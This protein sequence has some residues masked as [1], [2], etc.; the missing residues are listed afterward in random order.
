MLL[1]LLWRLLLLLMSGMLLLLL[2]AWLL[3]GRGHGL[4]MEGGRQR[5]VLVAHRVR[6]GGQQQALE[7]ILGNGDGGRRMVRRMRVVGGVVWIRNVGRRQSRRRARTSGVRGR[8]VRALR[9]IRPARWRERVV[10]RIG[11]LSKHHGV[12]ERRVEGGLHLDAV[13]V[14][15]RRR[16]GRW[17]VRG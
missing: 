12:E 6:V 8:V 4:R 3:L 1:L 5:G 16:G 2:V 7:D 14:V 17:R 15:L 11:P 13:V 10:R 9:D